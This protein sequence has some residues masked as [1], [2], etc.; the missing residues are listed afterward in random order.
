MLRMAEGLARLPDDQRMALDPRH[1]RGLADA[2][3]GRELDPST[4]AAGPGR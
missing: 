2:V 3:A 4:A 1:Q